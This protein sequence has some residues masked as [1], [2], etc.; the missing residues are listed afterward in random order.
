MVKIANNAT[1]QNVLAALEVNREK[2]ASTQKK[3]YVFIVIAVILTI[4]SFYFGLGGFALLIGLVPAIYGGVLLYRIS[5]ELVAYKQ[6]FKIEVIGGALKNINESLTIQ[7]GLGIP[8]N[9]FEITQLFTQE[10][11]RY[12]SEDL[13]SGKAD[14]TSFY[15]AEVHAEYKTQVQTKNGTRTE[16]HDI[17]KGIIFVADFNKNFKAV[18]VVRPKDLFGRMGAWFSKNVFSFGGNTLVELEN[19]AFN[20]AFTTNSTDQV[21]ARYILTPAMMERILKLNSNSKN[22]ISLSFI[23]NR[24]NIAFPLDRNYFEAPVFKSL[25]KPEMLNQDIAAIKFMYEIVQ[26]LDLN[27]RIWGKS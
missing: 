4:A 25:L 19:S 5:D 6:A 26:E 11:D 23:N 13:I 8:S 16:W 7:P 20:E 24:M 18:T 2:I 9:E 12:Q 21:E 14:R 27:T 22:T 17:F 1:L 10:P 15:F 3:G